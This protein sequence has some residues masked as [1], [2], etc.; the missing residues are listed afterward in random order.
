MGVAIK[1]SPCVWVFLTVL[2]IVGTSGTV[3][4]VQGWPPT[5]S[6]AAGV[7]VGDLRGAGGGQGLS[8][9]PSDD[10]TLS[11]AAAH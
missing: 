7:R 6:S 8:A 1:V 11:C 4:G 2:F 5:Q 3:G 9:A 10:V